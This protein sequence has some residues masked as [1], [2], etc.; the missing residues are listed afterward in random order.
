MMKS[1]FDQIE[2]KIKE[3]FEHGSVVLPW[4]NS[5]SV[6]LH[7]LT[8]AIH[9]SIA[10]GDFTEQSPPDIFTVYLCPQDAA[11]I[12][13]QPN[14]QEA[15]FP[16]INE[17]ALEYNLRL[18]KTPTIHLA[19]KNSLL[20]TEVRVRANTSNPITG[21]TSAVPLKAETSPIE[22]SHHKMHG[23]LLLENE[24]TYYLDQPVINIGRKSNNHLVVD[25]LRVSRNHAQIRTAET[26]YMIFDTGSSGGTYINGERITQRQLKPGDVISLAGVKL[27]FT[28]EQPHQSPE[29]ERQ[30][31]SEM[32]ASSQGNA[33]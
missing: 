1:P 27:I 4:M 3:L 6:F 22:P 7:H 24:S 33:C 19:K 28:Q 30:I 25:D 5:E 11:L 12:E 10:S 29:E 26:G 14:W 17:I 21:Q 13:S 9:S 20:P 2:Q 18:E 31:T 8:E 15:F 32:N 16:I 23:C